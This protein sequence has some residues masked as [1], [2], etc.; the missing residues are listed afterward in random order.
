MRIVWILLGASALAPAQQ[1]LDVKRIW[2]QAPHNAFTDLVR[3][4]GVFYC[5]FREGESHASPDGRI[6]VLRSRDGDAW[7]SAALISV[8]SGDLRDPKLSVTPKGELMLL[9]AAALPP[10][11][12]HRHQTLAWFSRDGTKWPPPHPVGEPGFWLWRVAWHK[13]K[14]YGAGYSTK[15]DSWG[16]KIYVS[17]DAGRT[18]RVLIP[19]AGSDME[20]D[21]E[22]AIA[23]EP[24]DTIVWLTRRTSTAMVQHTS[25][26]TLRGGLGFAMAENIGG[27]ALLRL[28]NGR[29]VAAGRLYQ[30]RRRTALCWLD[31]RSGEMSE[32]LEL[33]SDGDNSYPGLVYEN[34]VLWVSYYSSHEGKASIYLARVKLN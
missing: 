30:P 18:F 17:E 8:S 4:N 32:F 19:E 14:G 10:G 23:F 21:T 13:G 11:S 15:P 26:A 27:P 33:P 34:G 6:R 12:A 28:P 3:F 2:D 5:V 24:P 31:F 29:F 7:E 16:L 25:L 20:R 22:T 1:L 9:A